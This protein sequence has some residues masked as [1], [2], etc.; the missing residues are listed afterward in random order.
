MHLQGVV[1]AFK[2]TD[3]FADKLMSAKIG[4]PHV[5]L[6]LTHN[7]RQLT[8]MQRDVDQLIFVQAFGS[9]H[10]ISCVEQRLSLF[11]LLNLARNSKTD[12]SITGWADVPVT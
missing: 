11:I 12:P 9:G 5:P 4:L 7:A 2:A 8:R 6:G 10:T 3:V 1:Y